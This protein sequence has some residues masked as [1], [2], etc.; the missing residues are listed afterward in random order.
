VYGR[1]FITN[2]DL[3]D[4]FRSDAPLTSPEVRTFY[5]GHDHG[6]TDYPTLAEQ[7]GPV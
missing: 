1:P 3:V 6:Y 5:G 7:A 2:P 4:R